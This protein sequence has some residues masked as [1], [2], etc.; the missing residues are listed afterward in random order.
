MTPEIDQEPVLFEPIS[1][2]P[3]E[4]KV[5]FVVQNGTGN[6]E[7]RVVT[8]SDWKN[9][10]SPALN[11]LDRLQRDLDQIR[12]RTQAIQK[13]RTT[14]AKPYSSTE[15]RQILKQ[16]RNDRE[17]VSTSLGQNRRSRLV[18]AE[19]GRWLS[20]SPPEEPLEVRLK[21]GEQGEV[22]SGNP[23]SSGEAAWRMFVFQEPEDLWT[24]PSIE[25]LREY[26]L[27]RRAVGLQI[28]GRRGEAEERLDD[29]RKRATS[30]IP[31]ELEGVFRRVSSYD[32]TEPLLPELE[33]LLKDA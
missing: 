30:L 23:L 10:V 7:K 2:E 13:G 5:I 27:L 1:L 8:L 4:P 20:L 11:G 22:V 24:H 32:F 12:K 3:L 25:M 15:K 14:R 19:Q 33:T 18:L 17:R 28:E 31:E 6:E 21:T 26:F 29:F 16:I 9:A